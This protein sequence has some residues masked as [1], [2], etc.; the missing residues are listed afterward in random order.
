M[1]GPLNAKFI[2]LFTNV[3]IFPYHEPSLWS[4]TNLMSYTPNVD[5]NIR[6]I[7]ISTPTYSIFSSYAG[8]L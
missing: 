7:F 5:F 4:S 3:S 8:L 1:H 6:S 2:T